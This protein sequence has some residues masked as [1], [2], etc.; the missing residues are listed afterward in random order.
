MASKDGGMLKKGAWAREVSS[1]TDEA[2]LLCEELVIPNITLYAP[3]ATISTIKTS[4]KC[5]D[6]KR[7]HCNPRGYCLLNHS[8]ANNTKQ[9]LDAI[10][11]TS[12]MN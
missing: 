1:E 3:S 4:R 8:N 11:S 10:Y 2:S 5:N 6:Y 9:P 7:M 12:N